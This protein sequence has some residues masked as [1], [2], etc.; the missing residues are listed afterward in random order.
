MI[1]SAREI[2]ETICWR[3]SPRRM[4]LS[5]GK[6]SGKNVVFF[7]LEM[8]RV[9]LAMRLIASETYVDLKRLIT[10]RLNTEDWSKV[11]AGLWLSPSSL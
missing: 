8:S 2:S 11:A 6:Y 10:G 7:S 5:A 1:F 9:Q 3:F 4:L